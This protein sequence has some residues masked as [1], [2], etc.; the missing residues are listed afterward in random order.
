MTTA[1]QMCAVTKW[2]FNISA[3]DP[4]YL[5]RML[6]ILMLKLAS[7]EAAVAP[8][9]WRSTIGTGWGARYASAVGSVPN[10]YAS[11]YKQNI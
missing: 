9:A 10:L 2:L 7:P 11:P 8:Q 3:A 1:E 5:E 6:E 4:A